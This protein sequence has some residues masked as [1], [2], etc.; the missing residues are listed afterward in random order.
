MSHKAEC[1]VGFCLKLKKSFKKNPE[2]ANQNES[3]AHIILALHHRSVSVPFDEPLLFVNLLSL[4]IHTAPQSFRVREMQSA[5]EAKL[6]SIWR[7]TI[8]QGRILF[9]GPKLTE[10]G[11]RRGPSTLPGR[12][13]NL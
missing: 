12:V 6:F 5:K 7:D 9:M 1:Q 3:I 8:P 11:L 4:D 2:T 13:D 10:T